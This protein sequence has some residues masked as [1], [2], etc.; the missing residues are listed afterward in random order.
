M[1]VAFV[2]CA[3]CVSVCVLLSDVERLMFRAE[4]CVPVLVLFCDCYVCVLCVSVHVVC[5]CFALCLLSCRV[6]VSVLF[7]VCCVH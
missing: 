6:R 2:L 3:C 1:C 5:L 7:S 4:C